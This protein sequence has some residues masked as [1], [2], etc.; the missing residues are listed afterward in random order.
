MWRSIFLAIGIGLCLLG[1]ECTVIER[2]VLVSST[3]NYGSG[4][5]NNGLLY[6][7]M[8]TSPSV[9]ESAEW[10]PWC[11]MTIGIVVIIYTISI[12]RRLHG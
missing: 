9:I 12:P 3:N 7:T 5:V 4:L 8:P 11:F 6:S 2:A 10:M 1:L